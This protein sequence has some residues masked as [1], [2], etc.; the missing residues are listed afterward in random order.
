MGP[1]KLRVM[2][3]IWAALLLSTLIYLVVALVVPPESTE[4]LGRETSPLMPPAFAALAVALAAASIA[5]PRRMAKESLLQKRF[6][7]VDLAADKRMFS[8]AKGRAR[9]FQD[10]GAARAEAFP[11]LQTSF[12]VGMALAEAIALFGFVLLY[13]GFELSWGLPFFAVCWVLM[14]GRY[15]SPARLDQQLEEAYDADLEQQT[16]RLS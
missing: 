12:I 9:R 4:E 15:P 11:A 8:D 2:R 3:I 16:G 6:A 13:L 10:S 5:V 7:L 1:E 14:A